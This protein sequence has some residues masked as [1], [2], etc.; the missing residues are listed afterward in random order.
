MQERSH[1]GRARTGREDACPSA[2]DGPAENQPINARVIGFMRNLDCSRERAARA[3]ARCRG[4]GSYHLVMQSK[5]AVMQG[6]AANLEVY[7]GHEKN[8]P[9]DERPS[10]PEGW[11]KLQDSERALDLSGRDRSTRSEYWKE[12]YERVPFFQYG[13]AIRFLEGHP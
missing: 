2:T 6:G 12:D 13:S 4:R 5:T 10:L 1:L 7:C 8:T 11:A 3:K 9:D